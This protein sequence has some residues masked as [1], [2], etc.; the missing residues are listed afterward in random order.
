MFSLV[1]AMLF[2]G[3]VLMNDIEVGY[4][5]VVGDHSVSQPS[6]R[7]YDDPWNTPTRASLGGRGRQRGRAKMVGLERGRRS[8]AV[9]D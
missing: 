6:R 9:T 3:T 2:A 1:V 8:P 4:G 5:E 7:P